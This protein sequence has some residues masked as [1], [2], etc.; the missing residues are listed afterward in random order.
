M[1]KTFLFGQFFSSLFYLRTAN[2]ESYVIVHIQ[3]QV[4]LNDFNRS[5]ILWESFIN[6]LSTLDSIL[7]VHSD[8][9]IRQVFVIC[10]IR[11]YEIDKIGTV[12]MGI[13]ELLDQLNFMGLWT[14]LLVLN[15]QNRRI[16]YVV[17]DVRETEARDLTRIQPN[18]MEIAKYERNFAPLP[19]YRRWIKE[20]HHISMRLMHKVLIA[21]HHKS[22]TRW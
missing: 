8:W 12:T 15:A 14:T 19:S 21:E 9:L 3:Y 5:P 1:F 13:N 17:G 18:I 4:F 20:I 6:D 7:K 11:H 2:N 10:D 16:K 22:I